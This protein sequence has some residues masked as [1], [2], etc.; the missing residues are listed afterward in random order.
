MQTRGSDAVDYILARED[1]RLEETKRMNAEREILLALLSDAWKEFTQ[2]FRNGCAKLNQFSPTIELECSDADELRFLISRVQAGNSIPV[3]EFVLD[4]RV[5]RIVV[6]DHWN[7]RAESSIDMILLGRKVGF[8]CRRSGLVLP[9][10]VGRL[11]KQITR[12]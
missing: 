5:P 2:A 7:D 1:A 10:L 9:E 11:L 6:T 8:A 4:P 3:L 12:P